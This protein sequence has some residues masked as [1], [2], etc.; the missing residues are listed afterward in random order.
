MK[1]TSFVSIIIVNYNGKRWLEKCLSSLKK[2]T[3]KN[4]EIIFVDNASNDNSLS[5]VKKNYPDVKTFSLKDN[6]GFAGGNNKGY[7]LAKGELILFLNNDTY[8]EECFLK[9]FVAAFNDKRISIAQS[10]LVLFDEKTIDSCGSFWTYTTFMYYFGNGKSERKS[11]YNKQFNLFSV[12]GASFMVRREVI[13][14]I[15]LFDEA[16]WNYYE[17]TDFCHRAWMFGYESWYCPKAVCYHA[18]GGT[19]LSFPN[20]FVQYHNFKNKLSSFL[21]NFELI[22]LLW[23]IPLY[24]AINVTLSIFWVF[25]LKVPNALSLY[26]AFV[27]NIINI[28]AT[29]KSRRKIQT[30]RLLRDKVVFEKTTRNPKFSYYLSLL[31]T[32]FSN[33][34]D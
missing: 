10:K 20:S 34:E 1:N 33:Y 31:T 5:F 25:T 2:Q 7:K 27:W 30:E 16:Y 23:V 24:L 21:K 3:Y 6:I 18:M 26:K 8:V 32:N 12:K 28:K 29:L 11:I 9:D 13:E 17:E 4:F 22:T 14:K 19:S 15:G